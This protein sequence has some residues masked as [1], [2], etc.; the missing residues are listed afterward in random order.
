MKPGIR[1]VNASIRALT[2]MV[3]KIDPEPFNNFPMQGPLI[4]IAN[5]INI[6]EAPIVYTRLYPRP[7]TAL[8]KKEFWD[9]PFTRFLLNLWDIIPLQRGEVDRSAITK[10]VD[11]LKQGKI[12][13]VFPEGTRSEKGPMQEGK[14]GTILLALH[15]KAPIV[16]IAF[17]G[18][19][20]FAQNLKHFK[21]TDFHIRVGNPFLLDPKG[22]ALSREVRQQ[23]IDEL[24]YQIA[25]LLP[26][27]YRGIYSDLSKA[28]EDFLVFEP[29]TP[30]NLTFAK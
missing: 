3:C 2:G 18:H 7:V 1:I 16:P 13:A 20:N 17:Y 28:T 23:M 6:L 24:M 9:N 12:L 27:S 5:H 15:S 25:A 30:S 19:E 8:A 22:T 10:G 11:A 21:R 29:G 4:G 14:P 26:A